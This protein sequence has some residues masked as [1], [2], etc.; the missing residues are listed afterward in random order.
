MTTPA[1]RPP[2]PATLPRS[3][4]VEPSIA[5][6]ERARHA[7]TFVQPKRAM[8]GVPVLRPHPASPRARAIQRAAAPDP[9]TL[10]QKTVFCRYSREGG[11]SWLCQLVLG[12]H[13]DQ[14]GLIIQLVRREFS[15]GG[16]PIVQ[17]FYEYW[18]TD[19]D[20]GDVAT[21]A[22]LFTRKTPMD[23]F[24]TELPSTGSCTFTGALYF[25]PK[26]HA[27]YDDIKGSFAVGTEGV[28]PEITMPTALAVNG[29]IGAPLSVRQ[30][31]FTWNKGTKQAT[32]RVR[33]GTPA[34]LADV[35]CTLTD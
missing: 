1:R 9:V 7:A 8:A 20:G 32:M 3:N 18:E 6:A 31:D 22:D 10:T 27:H 33:A 15:L 35:E 13:G 12:R 21:G 5:G 4:P 14:S 16:A 23:M 29:N 17:E 26:S 28:P 24:A 30:L 19:F 2:H 34:A 11:F 25:V